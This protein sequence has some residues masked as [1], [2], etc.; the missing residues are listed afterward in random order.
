MSLELR[1]VESPPEVPEFEQLSWG[2]PG[3]SGCD[4]RSS[5]N[6]WLSELGDVSAASTDL[7]RLASGAYMADRLIRRGSGFSRSLRLHVQLHRSSAWKAHLPHLEFLLHWLSGDDWEIT[8]S[9]D[10]LPRPKPA[11]NDGQVSEAISLL[12]GGL[13][14]FCGA[15]LSAKPKVFVSH[16]DN[17]TVTA[18]QARSWEWLTGE[19][20]VEG[21]RIQI[22]LLEEQRKREN[23]TRTRALLFYALAI[24]AA[25]ARAAA[26]VEVPENGYTS[27]NPALGSDRG[28]V[29]STR[30]THPWTMAQIHRLL[31]LVGINIELVNPYLG[32]TKGELVAKALAVEPRIA[33]GIPTTLSCAK[34]DGRVYKGGNPNLN[35]GLCV[36]C[37]T[38]RASIH[39]ADVEDGTI[40]LSDCLAG[41]AL[42][43]LKSRRSEDVA[44]VRSSLGRTIDEFSLLSQGPYPEDFNLRAAAG[45]CR[46]GLAE[47]SLLLEDLA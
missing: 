31:E 3:D 26:V 40:Y 44:A 30:S 17:P 9:S 47:L 36:A 7:V 34:L 19:G 23:S 18:S 37:L 32:L 14:S 20:G 45:L 1:P 24:A 13:D 29:L 21:E 43:S 15:L 10:G 4:V 41:S 38:R 6:P 46:R 25:D 16:T 27:L 11:E 12:S 42:R 39:G 8:V 2:E 35:C 22:T 5:L 28:G 33:D